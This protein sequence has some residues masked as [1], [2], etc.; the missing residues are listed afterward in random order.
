M[1]LLERLI[2]AMAGGGIMAVEV[3][4]FFGAFRSLQALVVSLLCLIA[5]PKLLSAVRLPFLFAS[6][7]TA[8]F[9]HEAGGNQ[10]GN[11]GAVRAKRGHATLF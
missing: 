1:S 5:T 8:G 3:Q 9:L 11:A 7:V 4:D 6:R 2:A 10:T